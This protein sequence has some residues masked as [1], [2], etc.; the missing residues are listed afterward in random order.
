MSAIRQFRRANI[1]F[2]QYA[3]AQAP[4]HFLAMKQ[5]TGPLH[6]KDQVEPVFPDVL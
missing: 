3:V 6:L 2:L 1:T 4:G 5:Y